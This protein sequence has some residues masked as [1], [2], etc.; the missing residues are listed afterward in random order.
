MAMVVAVVGM[1]GCGKGELA[2]V[3]SEAGFPVYSMGDMIR[4]E[5]DSRGLEG[6]PLIFG[7]IAQELRDEFGYAVLAERLAPIVDEAKK[8][9]SIVMIEGMRGTDEKGVFLD[10]WS[11]DFK[12]VAIAADADLRFQRITARGRAEDG[13]RPS[14]DARDERESR[15]GVSELMVGADW[16]LDNSEDLNTFKNR[17]QAWLKA[18]FPSH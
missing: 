11:D 16:T 18:L 17:S 4:A 7:R 1:P 12:V 10:Y 5:V 15:W 2:A 6:D 3:V 9:H 14:F 13:D 8:E